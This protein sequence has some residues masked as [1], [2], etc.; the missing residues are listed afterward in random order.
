MKKFIVILTAMLLTIGQASARNKVYNTAEHLPEAAKN[1]LATHFPGI[2]MNHMKIDSDIISTEYEVIL[3]DGTEIDFNRNGE[4]TSVERGHISVPSSL[5]PKPIR[6]YTAKRYL[7]QKI[8][9]IDRDQK[10]YRIGLA[11]GINLRFDP[12]GQFVR[13]ED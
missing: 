13:V 8:I 4:W 9:D 12:D 10:S 5:I 1:M 11:N 6:E 3:N 2:K 7:G